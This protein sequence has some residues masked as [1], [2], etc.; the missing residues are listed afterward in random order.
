MAW[1][2][3]KQE[4]PQVLI[5]IPC[6]SGSVNLEWAMRLSQVWRKA[7][8][9]TKIQ[10]LPEPQIDAARCKGIEIGLQMGVENIFFWDADVQP[11]PDIIAK[12]LAHNKPIVSALYAR[13]YEPPWLEMLKQKPEG[14]TPLYEGD[15]EKGALVECDAIGMG[16]CLIKTSLLKEI[17]KPWFQW[18][19]YYAADGASE[20]FSFCRKVK[21]AGFKIYVDTSLICPHAGQIKFMPSPKGGHN[22]ELM[23]NTGLFSLE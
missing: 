5:V 18:T 23:N 10:T 16:C 1:E 4:K 2:Q 3:K 15:Y 20:D 12:L 8:S 9:G 21:R 17:E 11:P 13:R 19:N 7:P 22:F 6:S 14:L